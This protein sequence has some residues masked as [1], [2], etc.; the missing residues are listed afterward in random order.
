MSL[1]LNKKALLYF[2]SSHQ[3]ATYETLSDRLGL[4]KH[5]IKL[6]VESLL[7]SYDHI[8]TIKEQGGRL[9]LD[10]F[11]ESAFKL[12][13]TENLLLD[14][15]LNSFHK[16]QAIFF[17]RLLAADDYVSA[18]NLAE[19]LGISR[20]SL[21][22]D[23][24]R[25]KERLK[26]YRL[27]I[28]SKTGVGLR[29]SGS[30]LGKRLLYLH[31]VADYIG[32]RFPLPRDVL[33]T[34]MDFVKAKRFPLEVERTFRT[35]LGLTISRADKPIVADEFYWFTSQ[36]EAD[37]PKIFYDILEEH[38]RRPLTTVERQFLTFPMN[39]GLLSIE[40]MRP[41]LTP[42][43]EASLQ[44]TVQEF[45][46]TLDITDSANVLHCHLLYMVNRSLVQW[47]FAEISLR[48]QF[49][50]SSFSKIVAQFFVDDF[51]KKLG[52]TVNDKEVI[53]LAAWMELLLARKSKPLISKIA[54]VTQSGK[55]FNYLVE[56]QIRQVLGSG[57]ELEFLDFTNHPPYE[58]LDKTYDLVFTDN[59]MYSQELLQPFLS[60]SLVT[61][62]NQAERE[63]LERRVLGRKI[64]IYCQVLPVDFD[65]SLDY[66]TNLNRIL[67]ILQASHHI[68]SDIKDKLLEKEANHS[69][70]SENGYAFPHL[71]D[72]SLKQI[73]LLVAANDNLHI[74]SRQG[75][76]IK[77]FILL[78]VPLEL[79]DFN[80]DLLFKIF[81]NTFRM[82]TTSRIKER[83]GLIE[84]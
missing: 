40:V 5:S 42:L 3:T 27:E 54:V 30:E 9:W 39:I 41:E 6:L 28:I 10:I 7:Y 83:L 59:L 75:I 2:L 24:V 63:A 22:R 1:E 29:L 55:S 37:L 35:S 56:N 57:I 58:D 68:S 49:I 4:S 11:D 71:T 20:R 38:L 43:I 33:D 78:F 81:D 74:M 44:R 79:D 14:T 21:T 61:K 26:L 16:R 48:E 8:L 67:E 46:I 66:E 69:A 84:Q 51:G 73:M 47:Q 52:L 80:Q 31:D 12:L 53:L 15:D 34:Y 65:E 62:E 25:M 23:L 77:D 36:I 64:Q 18:D 19:E 72:S 82:N 70:I 60:L 13:V 50:Q 32:D 17:D 45:G 76:P